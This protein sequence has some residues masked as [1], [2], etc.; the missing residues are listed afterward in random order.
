[1]NKV[2]TC[3]ILIA[4]CLFVHCATKLAGGTDTETGGITMVGKIRNADGSAGSNTRVQVVPSDHDPVAQGPVPDSLTDTTDEAG[5]FALYI[6]MAQEPDIAPVVFNI[7]AV[8]LRDRTRL[9]IQNVRSDTGDV[10]VEPNTLQRPG[11][12]RV[13]IS[14]TGTSPDGYIYI[15][16]T[17]IHA[18]VQ[19]D[20]ADSNYV[21]LDSVPVGLISA[22][23]Y[24]APAG[25]PVV[26]ARNVEVS[27]DQTSEVK[28][29]SPKAIYYSVGLRTDA[30]YTGNASAQNGTLSLSSPA[31]DNVGIGDEIRVGQERV[32]IA[33]RNSSTSFAI[34]T[35]TGT[36][37]PDFTLQSISIFRAFDRLNTALL[38][39]FGGICAADSNHLNTRDLV[40]GNYQLHIA[41]YAD[42]V[43]DRQASIQGWTTSPVNFIKIYTP[44]TAAEVGVS[45]RHRGVWN[46]TA[47]YAMH[48]VAGTSSPLGIFCRVPHVRIDGLQVWVQAESGPGTGIQLH[49]QTTG[50]FDVSNS[51]IRGTPV[52]TSGTVIGVYIYNDLENSL[53]V[54]LWNNVIYDFN[55]STSAGIQI[56]NRA[57][58]GTVVNNTFVNCNSGVSGWIDNVALRNNL[59]GECR[60]GFLPWG[61]FSAE[62]DYNI[63]NNR[64]NNVAAIHSLDSV[65]VQFA[66]TANDDFHLSPSD[67]TARNKG[68]ESPVPGLFL[69]DIDGEIRASPWDVGADEALP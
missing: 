14:Q 5:N 41:C 18:P 42:G 51:L 9:L 33:G 12:I 11:S 54:R 27:P 44:V 61:L 56:Q 35:A 47:A 64:E 49:N 31:P 13:S 58:S 10:E 65:F 67:T 16:G 20:T 15:P 45:Q 8:H 25:G 38:V 66:D 21:I 55:D 43:D 2:L 26:V 50:E 57:A 68:M 24:A 39:E 53:Y 4:L 40:S 30:L 48:I 62:N 22:V 19:R 3:L 46:S 29:V 52:G 60:R 37:A 1:M 6:P 28:Q 34:Q 59:F 23:D 36:P 69:N 63:S 7:E 32:Y 17:S